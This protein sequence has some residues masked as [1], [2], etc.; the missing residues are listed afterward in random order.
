MGAENPPP[1]KIAERAEHSLLKH[2]FRNRLL[3]ENRRAFPLVEILFLLML[4]FSAG[5]FYTRMS[6]YWRWKRDEPTG[7]LGLLSWLWTLAAFGP[8]LVLVIVAP[9]PELGEAASPRA[10]RRQ[11]L[12][13][14]SIVIMFVLEAFLL[15]F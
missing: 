7:K 12:M 8:F 13:F 5:A 4:G 6:A 11:I 15:T 3:R 10:R 2:P 9:N 1:G 14:L